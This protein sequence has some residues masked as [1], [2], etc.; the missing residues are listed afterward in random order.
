MEAGGYL[1]GRAHQ[2]NCPLAHY[3]RAVI[4]DRRVDVLVNAHA[5][6]QLT[7]YELE[8][9]GQPWYTV[10]PLPNNVTDFVRGWDEEV[11][12]NRRAARPQKGIPA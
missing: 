3:L 6:V 5:G 1:Y 7:R 10:L 9:Q 12:Q 4:N 11:I 2:R 8:R